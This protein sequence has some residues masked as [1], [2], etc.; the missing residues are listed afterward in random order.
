MRRAAF[1]L[2]LLA[3]AF[4]LCVLG[5]GAGGAHA[6]A[7]Y[8]SPYTYDQTYSTALRLLR[9]DMGLKVTEKDPDTG[10]VLF[11]YTSPE[12]GKKV[13]PGSL[14]IV[15]GKSTTKV[16]VQLPSLPSYHEQYIADALAKKLVEQYGDPIK[17]K[18]DD[19]PS[20]GEGDREKAPSDNTKD[21]GDGDAEKKPAD[22]RS[23]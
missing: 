2:A 20:E 15:R 9:V 19:K 22:K 17:A 14:E 3:L 12:S 13:S 8:E 21:K 7:L 11:E 10:Y 16:S 5:F 23:G 1:G 6:S 4:A 18:R